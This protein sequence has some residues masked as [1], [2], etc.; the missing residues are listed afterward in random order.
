M[1]DGGV[2]LVVGSRRQRLGEAREHGVGFYDWSFPAEMPGGRWTPW[3]SSRHV[4]AASDL[5][6]CLGS[7]GG[8]TAGLWNPSSLRLGTPS[9][10]PA[11]EGSRHASDREHEQGRCTALA[12]GSRDVQD[13]R[14]ECGQFLPSTASGRTMTPGRHPPPGL[15]RS[16]NRAR[17]RVCHQERFTR[18]QSRAI[19]SRIIWAGRPSRKV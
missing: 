8:C 3:S 10:A 9:R 6:L 19:S 5:S 2:R 4:L 13:E 1:A 14:V 18:P 16:T 7:A 11:R 15:R 17:W 12:G